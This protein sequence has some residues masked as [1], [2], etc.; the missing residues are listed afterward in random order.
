MKRL[1]A[2][3]ILVLSCAM[4]FAQG[5]GSTFT[6]K[7]TFTDGTGTNSAPLVACDLTGEI[8]CTLRSG[9]TQR[10]LDVALASRYY[11]DSKNSTARWAL[12]MAWK[13][14]QPPAP[15]TSTFTFSK[16]ECPEGW[17]LYTE[18]STICSAVCIPD[19]H[20]NTCKNTCGDPKYT[21]RKQKK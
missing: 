8:T 11:S 4:G 10:D 1:A 19:E 3:V 14:A 15:I 17:E 18:I 13:L 5:N 20:S 21:C 2:L 6:S 12:R 7:L 9:A 16:Q